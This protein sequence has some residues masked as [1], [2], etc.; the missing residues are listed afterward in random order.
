MRVAGREG[1]R[2]R[3]REKTET[4]GMVRTNLRVKGKDSRLGIEGNTKEEETGKR[5]GKD[6][7]KRGEITP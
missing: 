1:R 4:T 3:R 5:A 2:E 7:G 6:A